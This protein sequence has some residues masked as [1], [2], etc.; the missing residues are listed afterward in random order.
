MGWSVRNGGREVVAQGVGGEVARGS[1][2][3][4]VRATAMRVSRLEGGRGVDDMKQQ[5][6]AAHVP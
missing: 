6:H 3:R 4:R 5:K 1:A 2:F